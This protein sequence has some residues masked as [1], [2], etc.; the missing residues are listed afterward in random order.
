ML[1][2]ISVRYKRWK[3]RQESTCIEGNA[4]W[5]IDKKCVES[6]SWVKVCSNVFASNFVYGA[7]NFWLNWFDLLQV[8]SAIYFVEHKIDDLNQPIWCEGDVV[9]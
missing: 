6:A 2:P 1:I 8:A 7:T 3:K 4:R 9:A 5:I